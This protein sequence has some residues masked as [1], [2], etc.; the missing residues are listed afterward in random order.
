MATGEFEGRARR[1]CTECRF[2]HFV[3]P[4]V[5]VGAMVMRDASLLLVQRRFNPEKFKWCLPAGYLDPGEL[6]EE[7]ARREVF[8]E[9]GLDVTITDLEAVYGN[10][11]GRGASLILIY[12]AVYAGGEP[13]AADDALAARFCA[14]DDVP[15]LAFDSTV[16]IVMRARRRRASGGA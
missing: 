4:R 11:N 15:V 16:D 8:E 6:P 12:N 1:I 10:T 3:E 14:L 13:V 7:T 9:T 2:I 5:S